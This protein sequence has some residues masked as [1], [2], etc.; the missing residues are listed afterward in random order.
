MSEFDHEVYAEPYKIKMVE[1]I[2]K[3]SHVEREKLI[4][5]AG[6]NVFNLKSKDVY[7]D[8]LTDSGTG[9]MSDA[10]WAEM[11]KGDEAYA[12]SMSFVKLQEAIKDIMGFKYVLPTHQGRGAEN[13]LFSTILK[14]DDIIIG[15]M[16][17]DTTKAHI[18]VRGAH[19]V[20]CVT[21]EAFDINSDYPFKGNMDL[22]KL[23]KLI[24][25]YGRERIPLVMITVTCN[26]G[27]GQPVSLENIK[28]TKEILNKYNIPLFFDSAR[29]AE[30]AYFIRTR[31]AAYKH[32]PIIEIARQM[33][34]YA[35][36]A[37]M[38]CKKDAIVNIG[39]FVALNN[40]DLYERCSQYCV[41]YEGFVTYGGLSGRDL[42]A[43]AQGLYDGIDY[44]YLKSRTYQTEYLGRKLRDIGIPIVWPIGGHAVY[45]N[46]KE[47]LPHIPQEQYPAQALVVQ[48]YIEGGVRGV[49]IGTVLADRDPLTGENRY[50]EL[51]LVRLAIPRRTYTISHMNVVVDAFEK[52][53]K[54]KDSIKGL[55]FTY[56]PKVLRHFTA[57]FE[58]V[59]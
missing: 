17:F 20:N 7:I 39:G 58:R 12:G 48:L 49:E 44:E 18:E 8:L 24:N 30:N 15:N 46:A 23:E 37:T 13:V 2:R 54:V 42:A 53:K 59:K 33:F 1:K 6:Y 35:D 5:E 28:K 40:P 32:V 14:K 22:E 51:E 55:S 4:R 9:A 38:S 3:I 21:K 11:L 47:F 25:E 29:F 34:S 45:V 31:E 57:R 50:P 26:S 10:Q 27:G 16:H 19:A 52:L 41:I 56:E 36:G 43:I